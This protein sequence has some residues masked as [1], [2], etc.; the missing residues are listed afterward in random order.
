MKKELEVLWESRGKWFLLAVET[1]DRASDYAKYEALRETIWGDP[2]DS[3][4]SVWIMAEKNYF[5]YGSSLY[6]GVFKQD[7]KGNFPRDKE[8]IVGFTYGYTGVNDQAAAFN[9]PENMFFYSLYAGIHPGYQNYNLG[10][11][12]KNF[13]RETVMGIL[14]INI[15]TCTY[16]PLTAVNAYRNIHKLGMNVIS[17]QDAHYKGFFGK[18]NRADVPCD[19]FLVSWD[20]NKESLRSEYVLKSQIAAGKTII[21]SDVEEV[22]GKNGPIVLPVPLRKSLN[23]K[24]DSVLGNYILLEIPYDFYTMLRETDVSS[25]KVRD[26]P[27]RWRMETRKAFHRLFAAGYKIVDFHSIKM[28]E[29]LRDFYVLA[30][31]TPIP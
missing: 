5:N 19:R 8:H 15:I 16:D 21:E 14:G 11:K 12:L 24:K 7:E 6:I 18:L 22:E 25:G 29:R 9:Q 23:I 3:F 28:K 10:I 20:L 13:Q 2:N 27:L 31:I 17:Y 26:I 1:S 30:P 4:A